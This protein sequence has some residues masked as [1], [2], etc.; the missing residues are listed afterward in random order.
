MSSARCM[1]MRAHTSTGDATCLRALNLAHNS[2]RA[3]GAAAVA[4]IVKATGARVL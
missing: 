2:L 1:T 3:V 4:R